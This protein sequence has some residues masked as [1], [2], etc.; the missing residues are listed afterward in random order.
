MVKSWRGYIFQEVGTLGDNIPALVS[1]GPGFPY[2]QWGNHSLPF[3]CPSVLLGQPDCKLIHYEAWWSSFVPLY[4]TLPLE[5]SSGSCP[6]LLL[7]SSTSH[8]SPGTAGTSEEAGAYL[9]Q[10]QAWRG[11]QGDLTEILAQPSAVGSGDQHS[12]CGQ[13][14]GWHYERGQIFPHTQ[15]VGTGASA[16]TAHWQTGEGPLA[17][18]TA[19]LLRSKALWGQAAPPCTPQ[20]D[21]EENT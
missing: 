20:T 1:L 14:S 18:G 15:E 8:S 10:S 13:H 7:L 4:M 3:F 11:P 2:V 12:P 16:Q 21:W 9:G 17:V 19:T 5:A 6:P